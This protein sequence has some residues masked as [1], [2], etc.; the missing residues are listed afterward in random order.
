MSLILWRMTLPQILSNTTRNSIIKDTYLYQKALSNSRMWNFQINTDM[1]NKN[2][3]LHFFDFQFWLTVSWVQNKKNFKEHWW[4]LCRIIR[5]ASEVPNHHIGKSLP[6]GL[7]IKFFKTDISYLNSLIFSR[8]KNVLQILADFV[9]AL[10]MHT[11]K[12]LNLGS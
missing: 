4:N 5:H 8:K 10:T 12:G 2:G 11:D 7:Y 1:F 3:T 6:I 9:K